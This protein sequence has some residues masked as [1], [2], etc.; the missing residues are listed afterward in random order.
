MGCS[1][2]VDTLADVKGLTGK[3]LPILRS[4]TIDRQLVLYIDAASVFRD[5]FIGKEEEESLKKLLINQKVEGFDGALKKIL[6]F[7][8]SIQ[9]TGVRVIVG[10]DGPDEALKREK[11]LER[12][13]GKKKLGS[14]AGKLAAGRFVNRESKKSV[15]RFCFVAKLVNDF[16]VKNK[17]ETIRSDR[18]A[19]TIGLKTNAETLIIANDTDSIVYNRFTFWIRPLKTEAKLLDNLDKWEFELFNINELSKK[20]VGES[21]TYLKMIVFAKMGKNDYVNNILQCGP[22]RVKKVLKQMVISLEDGNEKELIDTVIE[23]LRQDLKKFDYYTVSDFGF[24]A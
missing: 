3:L 21:Q 10:F 16:L 1:S 4:I 6:T 23:E 20:I 12:Y 19:E 9:A 2:I 11:I 17:I 14:V 8:R 18:E 15:F 22:D 13:G 5:L 7:N 24:I